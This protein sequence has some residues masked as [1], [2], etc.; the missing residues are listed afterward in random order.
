MEPEKPP[1]VR[2][3]ER[4][5]RPRGELALRSIIYVLGVFLTLFT[6]YYAATLWTDIGR[7][8]NVFFGVGVALFYLV[9]ILE[10]YVADPDDETGTAD[11]EPDTG[12]DSG[13]LAE[14]PF[15]DVL[16][17]PIWTKLDLVALVVGVFVAAAVSGYVEFHYARLLDRAPIYGWT[18]T[19]YY[20]GWAAMALVTDA[21]RRAFGNVIA[22]VVIA[23]I[24]YAFV[25]PVFDSPYLPDVFYHTGMDWTQVARHGAIGLTGVYG[26]ILEVG[27]TAV[28]IFLMFA[29]MAK[30]YGLMEFVLRMSREVRNVLESGVVQV[31]VVGSMIMGSITG[32]AAAN[33]ATTGS[34][35]IPM[36]KDQG[37]RKDFAC[38]IESVASS[39]GQMLPPIMGVAAFLM[40]DFL[41]IP[42]VEIVMA[43]ALPALLFY[44]AVG[45]AVHL[46]VH[47]FGWTT[48]ADGRFDKRILLGGIHYVLPLA[49][50]LYTLIVLRY[51]PLS[52]GLYTIVAMVPSALLK[53]LIDAHDADEE[54]TEVAVDFAVTTFDGLRQGAVDMAPL[55]GILA[56]LGVV[57]Q[58]VEQT[59]LGARISFRMVGLAGGVLVFLL[60]LAMLTSILFGLGM[61]TPA[62]YIVVAALVAP[63]LVQME[64]QSLTAHMFVFY[65]A[66]LSAIT[67]PVAVAVAVGARIADSDFLQSCKQALR[68]GA[69][70][71]V[72]P[73]AF[74]AND[75][76]IQ[77]QYVV[78]E[79][80]A[81]G[82]TAL[83][84]A[85]VQPILFELGVVLVGTVALVVA[86]VGYDGLQR[87]PWPHR[88][89]YL[90][91]A[92]VAMFAPMN[93]VQFAAAAFG[94]V[95]LALTNT[96]RLPAVLTPS[97]Q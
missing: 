2:L 22:G 82:G 21:T 49:V 25:G 58:M 64:V 80:R 88:L 75:S 83:L 6:V 16:D 11:D 12:E 85:L 39:G 61:P 70:G 74:V 96:G 37:V 59:G 36:I 14:T 19:D 26:F 90:G 84:E 4:F 91:V 20:V 67:P 33:T 27:A 50:L 89:V 66:M 92:F 76:I 18:T 72:I 31:A 77:W 95:V 56:S 48:S 28:A 17:H 46:T 47:K 15:A 86:T 1:T 62:A 57:I 78:S 87:L 24:A 79:A 69:P 29:G 40:A 7:Y 68:I 55:V 45:I 3:R 8:A 44:F 60:I 63:A 34:F 93:A 43:G 52:A 9:E 51:S 10:T 13:S 94:V 73:F 97:R 35:T 5:D 30:A 38:A 53:R 32:S 81:A 41:A 54:P 23:G 71:F 42:Y 65:F